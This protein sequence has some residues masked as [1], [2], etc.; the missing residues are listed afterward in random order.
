[1]P[2]VPFAAV[3]YFATTA[4]AAPAIMVP[5]PRFISFM[6]RG[7]RKRSRARAATQVLGRAARI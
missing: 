5:A 6:A 4:T 2:A 7:L 1:M 3:V